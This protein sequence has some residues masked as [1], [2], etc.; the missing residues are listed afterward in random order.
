MNSGRRINLSCLMV[1]RQIVR[2]HC[3]ERS[4]HCRGIA[5]IRATS[6]EQPVQDAQPR[7]DFPSS[8]PLPDE[9][10]I[11]WI[12]DLH[13]ADG[14]LHGREPIAQLRHVLAHFK[15]FHTDAE[16]L[17]IS[18]DI[19][20]SGAKQHYWLLRDEL[21]AAGIP[22]LVL[23]G[24][25]DDRGELVEVFPRPESVD[26]F[27]QGHVDVGNWRL[28]GLDTVSVDGSNQPSFCERRAAWLE[29]T[30]AG[31]ADKGKRC[32]VFMHHPVDATQI[33]QVLDDTVLDAP[34]L[35]TILQRHRER[36]E[37]LAFGHVHRAITGTWNGIAVCC[38]WATSHQTVYQARVD[39][40]CKEDVYRSPRFAYLR[41]LPSGVQVHLRSVDWEE[42]YRGAKDGVA[43]MI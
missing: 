25:H 7:A 42:A 23:V 22:A 30:L 10:R 21:A 9:R 3:A 35:T 27:V 19:S 6:D 14:D 12:T 38:N 11:L 1:G 24:N 29:L 31:A 34:E 39:S 18:G 40:L 36:V 28:I 33:A 41:L 15:R 4:L 8:R 26:G 5:L 2:A 43:S 17:V 20:D 16:L 13:L 37:L 32:I